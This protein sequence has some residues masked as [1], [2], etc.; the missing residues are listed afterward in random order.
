MIAVGATLLIGGIVGWFFSAVYDSS[1]VANRYAIRSLVD[2]L[3]QYHKAY[4]RYPTTE[5]GL[6]PLVSA[7]YLQP[8]PRDRWGRKYNYRFPST[9]KGV[10]F[11]VWTFGADGVA[12]GSDEN[13][14]IGNWDR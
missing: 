1:E 8:D 5:E 13:K 6:D 11:E 3:E 4:G 12:G 9:R 10:A 14:D 2:A 7:Q